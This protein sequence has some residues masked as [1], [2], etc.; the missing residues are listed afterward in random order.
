MGTFG[1]VLPLNQKYKLEFPAQCAILS[2]NI[3]ILIVLNYV[4][5]CSNLISAY[6]VQWS[7]QGNIPILLNMILEQYFYLF[8]K[9][10]IH[11]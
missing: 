7:N 2:L 11:I 1:S 4:E 6:T 8:F 3:I 10:S 9:I 5:Q